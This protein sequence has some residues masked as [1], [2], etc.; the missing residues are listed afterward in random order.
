MATIG[1]VSY[2]S[3][4]IPCR[5]LTTADEKSSV[6]PFF[7]NEAFYPSKI[8]SKRIRG[9]AMISLRVQFKQKKS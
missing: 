7:L 9:A 8:S 5:L 1:T 3:D 4:F 2:K 6:M